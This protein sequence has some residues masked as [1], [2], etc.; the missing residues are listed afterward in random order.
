MMGSVDEAE[1]VVQDTYLRAWRSYGSFEGRSSLRVWLYRIATNACLSA[2]KHRGRR[3]LPSGLG[4]PSDDPDAPTT[5]AE[6]GFAW[7]QPIPDSLVGSIAEDPATLVTLR[8][9]LRLALVA[10]LQYLPPRQ[11]AVLLLREVLELPAAEI[12]RVLGMSTPAVKSA[13]QRARDRIEKVAPRADQLALPTEPKQRA[14]LDTYMAAFEKADS[15]ALEQVLTQDAA[16]E[17]SPAVTWY[18]G[19]VTCIKVLRSAVGL[20]GEWLMV[21]TRANGQPAAVAYRRDAGGVHRAFGVVVLG[22]RG[23]SIDR[24]S[25]FADAAAVTA[26]GFPLVYGADECDDVGDV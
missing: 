23:D 9:G 7:L 18:S 13:L 21:P 19:L 14:L 3:P 10:S 17:V 24:I 11:R 15:A 4:A 1:D 16:L 22:I 25:V 12:G 26:F 5:M 20:P 6:P 2:L 8:E